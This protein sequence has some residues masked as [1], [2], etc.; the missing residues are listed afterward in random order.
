M[1]DEDDFEEHASVHR[2]RLGLQQPHSVS[3]DDCLTLFTKEEQVT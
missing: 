1:N 3:L 2:A